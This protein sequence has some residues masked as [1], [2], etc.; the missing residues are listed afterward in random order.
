MISITSLDTLTLA[1]SPKIRIQASLEV[2]SSR[3][4]I[5]KNNYIPVPVPV[6]V[7]WSFFEI[8][9]KG[10]GLVILTGIKLW[11]HI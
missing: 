5:W 7:S 10:G 1:V 11:A 2:K 8:I 4:I 9:P 6:P 3:T